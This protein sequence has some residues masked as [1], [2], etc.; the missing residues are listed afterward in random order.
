MV[1]GGT[2]WFR[3][4]CHP[5]I[6]SHLRYEQDSTT[7]YA[8]RKTWSIE[9]GLKDFWIS[10]NNISRLPATDS[11]PLGAWDNKNSEEW[12]NSKK[13]DPQHWKNRRQNG[14]NT[15][16]IKAPVGSFV[17]QDWQNPVKWMF[18]F[19]QVIGE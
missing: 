8:T 4:F 5:M 11:P 3:H 1:Y 14:W 10:F 15:V 17:G 7:F 12:V 19:M 6:Q 18:S 2:I 16:L 9:A 13:I